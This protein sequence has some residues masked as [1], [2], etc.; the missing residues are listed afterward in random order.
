MNY[1]EYMKIIKGIKCEDL[2][3]ILV[4]VL[5]FVSNRIY[6]GCFYEKIVVGSY[7]LEVNCDRS[8]RVIF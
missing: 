6:F 8:G 3:Y 5:D 1:E 4:Y 2:N 7:C